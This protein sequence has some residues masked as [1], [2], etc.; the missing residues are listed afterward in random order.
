[1]CKY[2]DIFLFHFQVKKKNKTKVMGVLDI[3]GF[4][5]FEVSYLLNVVCMSF[6]IQHYVFPVG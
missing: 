6:F 4:E 2:D 3:Y 1:M 5:V